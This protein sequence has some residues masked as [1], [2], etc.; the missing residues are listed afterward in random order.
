MPHREQ[1]VGLLQASFVTAGVAVCV[2]RMH[3]ENDILDAIDSYQLHWI[4]PFVAFLSIKVPF[5]AYK[6]HI[7]Y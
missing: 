6:M 3:Q 7:A 1:I 4:K 2:R 5:I